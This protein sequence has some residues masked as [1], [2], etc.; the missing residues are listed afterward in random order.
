M[1]SA[2]S[3]PAV[4]SPMMPAYAPA[5]AGVAGWPNSNGGSV[6]RDEPA[7]R[8]VGVV[9]DEPHRDLRPPGD[10]D[11]GI[12]EPRDGEGHVGLA[13]RDGH[14][15]EGHGG[16]VEGDRVGPRVD[17]GIRRI[18]LA[19]RLDL[20]DGY[21]LRRSPCQPRTRLLRDELR[22]RR[23]RRTELPLPGLAAG[24]EGIG[25]GGAATREGAVRSGCGG[26]PVQPGYPF[27]GFWYWPDVVVTR[28]RKNCA[29]TYPQDAAPM[30]SP[31]ARAAVTIRLRCMAQHR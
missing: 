4:G 25:V 19:E 3:S 15:R 17:A 14:H 28:S 31:P 16:D 24:E 18:L 13:G 8:L 21:A 29:I 12:G 2:P 23:V 22:Q 26:V 11:H 10:H 9:V 7:V 5:I 20:T 27:A 6:V 30:V 1:V